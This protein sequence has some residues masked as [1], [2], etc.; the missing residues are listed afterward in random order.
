MKFFPLQ[1]IVLLPV[2]KN[3]FGKFTHKAVESIKIF[4]DIIASNKDIVLIELKQ[5]K[6]PLALH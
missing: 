3:H 4:S 2:S 6:T 1:I 5:N